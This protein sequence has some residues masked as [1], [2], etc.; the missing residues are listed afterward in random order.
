MREFDDLINEHDTSWADKL[1]SLLFA[2]RAQTQVS[3]GYS[4]LMLMYG[5]E[6][7]IPRQADKDKE[8]VIPSDDENVLIEEVF[9]WS[10]NYFWVY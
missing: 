3:T 10:Q 1:N 4:P 8:P 6:A 7:L 9:N 2:Y 5:R